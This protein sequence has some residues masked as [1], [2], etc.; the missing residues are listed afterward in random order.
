M[1]N[2]PLPLL[3]ILL[4]LVGACDPGP[5]SKSDI[6]LTARTQPRVLA[7]R[8]RPNG[9]V[10]GYRIETSS[11]CRSGRFPVHVEVGLDGNIRQVS[12]PSY[13]HRY[14]RGVMRKSFLRQFVGQPLGRIGRQK[15]DAVSGAT[16]SCRGLTRAVAR[17]AKILSTTDPLPR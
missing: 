17:S 7:V 4:L 3:A 12:V 5:A 15:V 14:G 16:S 9:P 1:V 8:S 13:P 6:P 10:K 11:R 2:M